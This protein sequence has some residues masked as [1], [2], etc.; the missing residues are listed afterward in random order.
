MPTPPNMLRVRTRGATR[1]SWST[2]KVRKL[3][4]TGIRTSSNSSWRAPNGSRLSCGRPVRRRKGVG[5]QSVP[6]RAQ[7]SASP[8]AIIARRLQALVRQP[9]PQ[10][11]I[12]ATNRP[13]LLCW[14]QIEL[15]ERLLIE[16][17]PFFTVSAAPVLVA[18]RDPEKIARTNTLG[19]SIVRV[20]VS[21]P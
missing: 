16:K 11:P 19:A 21:A 3:E 14:Y 18:P 8:R 9:A 5:R 4:L 2:M 1:L 12:G 6:A 13:P 10:H 17:C 20:E 7:H 15:A